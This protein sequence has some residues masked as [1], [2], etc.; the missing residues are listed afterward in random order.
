MFL[1]ILVFQGLPMLHMACLYGQLAIIQ[2]LIESNQESVNSSDF[3]GRRPLHVVL[4]SQSSPNTSLCLRYLLEQG[5][6]VNR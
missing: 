3:E 2:R 5:A 6:D 4:S 1:F